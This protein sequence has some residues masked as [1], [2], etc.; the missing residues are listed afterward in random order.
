MKIFNLY[1]VKDSSEYIIQ[2]FLHRLN[3]KAEGG[4]VI[5]VWANFDDGALANAMS[6]TKFNDIKHRLGRYKPSTRWLRMADGTLVKPVA[7]LEGKMEIKGVEVSGSFEVF[8]SGGNWEFLLGKPLLKAFRAVHNYTD[9]TVTV[10]SGKL[11]ATLK[12]QFNLTAKTQEDTKQNTM[13]TAEEQRNQKGK[14][15]APTRREVLTYVHD[16]DG[17]A[18]DIA[19]IET[20]ETTNTLDPADDGLNEPQ[21][22]TQGSTTEIEVEAL[23]NDNNIYTRF[24]N[25]R[26]KER[27]EEILRLVKIGPDLSEGERSQ[28]QTFISEW[29]DVFALSV[30]EV[31]QVNNATHQLDIP[32]GQN[33]FH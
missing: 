18:A 30:N 16:F 26:K 19:Y 8:D 6:T 15:E 31:K 24:T 29:A 23:K 9:D 14:L 10:A 7:A 22:Y 2:P 32:P 13:D 25:P 33:L 11:S 20:P 4:E 27:V 1:N 28:V 21:E 3:I 17:H 12:N 5:R